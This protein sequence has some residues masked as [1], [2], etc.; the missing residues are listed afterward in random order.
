M[1]K[2]E[3]NVCSTFSVSETS[4]LYSQNAELLKIC[5]AKLNNLQYLHD[6]LGLVED[7][8]ILVSM[9]KNN[10]NNNHNFMFLYS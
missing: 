8:I 4:I 10:N 1:N 7:V 2:E 5:K 3:Q 6:S 9:K